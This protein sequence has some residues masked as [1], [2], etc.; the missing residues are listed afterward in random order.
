M[1]SAATLFTLYKCD[2]KRNPT[3]PRR[4]YMRHFAFA[5]LALLLSTTIASGQLN[6]P[7]PAS[8]EQDEIAR[9]VG[10]AMTSGGASTFLESLTDRIGGRITGSPESRATSELILKALKDAGFSN[11]HFEEYEISSGWQ[12]GPASGEVTVPVRRTLYVG[13]YG[14][15]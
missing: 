11:A 13:S 6:P 1:A 10:Y 3:I 12:R 8:A 7:N 14:W 15:A 9:I 5:I 4:S 2:L